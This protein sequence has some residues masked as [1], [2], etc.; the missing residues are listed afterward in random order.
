MYNQGFFCF[1]WIICIWSANGKS[2]LNFHQNEVVEKS[3]KCF[4]RCYH[5]IQDNCVISG[6][7]IKNSRLVSLDI[8]HMVSP[9]NVYLPG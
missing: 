2:C 3:G 9:P 6:A 8:G 7:P 1:S 5:P 4:M